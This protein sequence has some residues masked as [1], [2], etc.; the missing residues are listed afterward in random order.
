MNKMYALSG[1]AEWFWL[2]ARNI[3]DV[4]NRNWVLPKSIRES[5]P[6][7]I[8]LHASKTKTPKDQLEFI[9]DH[10]SSMEYSHFQRVNWDFYRGKLIGECTITGQ[11]L[12]DPNNKD[13]SQWAFGKHCFEISD[14]TLYESP[15][16][17][18]GQVKFFLPKFY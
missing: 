11:H 2:I 12:Y 18:K 8:Y 13:N 16:P 17:Y 3:K 10:L 7:R 5:L 9:I 15:T 6:A 4:E 1:Y 14:G